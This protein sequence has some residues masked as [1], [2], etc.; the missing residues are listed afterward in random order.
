MNL[1]ET[2]K[3]F[4]VQ[5]RPCGRS[6]SSR[7]LSGYFQV[8]DMSVL[9]TMPALRHL[10]ISHNLLCRMEPM[11]GRDLP[12]RLETLNMSHNR[13]TRIGGIGQCFLLRVVDLRHNRIKVTDSLVMFRVCMHVLSDASLPLLPPA[14]S[15]KQHFLSPS[16]NQGGRVG[17]SICSY[18][19]AT[20]GRFCR[21]GCSA[22]PSRL[23]IKHMN[24]RNIS[25]PP[26]LPRSRL[27]HLLAPIHPPVRLPR[28]RDCVTSASKGWN[29]SAS[30]S[31]LTWATT[32]SQRRPRRALSASTVPSSSCGLRVT[33]SP[34]TLGTGQP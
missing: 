3:L 32:S 5:P 21:R 15:S 8:L 26:R 7:R 13:I 27:R 24:G 12:P 25:T 2:T 18:L 30:W 14:N 19:H 4:D 23:I 33:R 17:V 29:T 10:D 31:S 20:T 6:T 22:S 1:A 11:D 28:S 9:T 16:E 34:D